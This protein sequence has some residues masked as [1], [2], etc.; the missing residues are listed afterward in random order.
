MSQESTHA[1]HTTINHHTIRDW[2]EQRAG[3]PVHIAGTGDDSDA[4][5][6]RIHFPLYSSDERLER[7]SWDTFFHQFDERRLCFVYQ[8]RTSTGRLSHF[9]R[10]KHE[11]GDEPRGPH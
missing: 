7:I 5:V 11:E 8:E 9:S 2:A 6:I 4:G 3:Y 1:T 10:L